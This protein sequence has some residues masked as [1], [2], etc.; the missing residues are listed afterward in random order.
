MRK[1][2][3]A[4]SP[5]TPETL[6]LPGG[7]RLYRVVDGAGRT[8]STETTVITANGKQVLLILRAG[9]RQLLESQRPGF[10]QIASNVRL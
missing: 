5:R 4:G 10:E 3:G 7:A 6:S 1:A 9:D 2:L 8:L